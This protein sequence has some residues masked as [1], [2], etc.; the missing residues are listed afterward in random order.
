MAVMTTVLVMFY[1]FGVMFFSFTVSSTDSNVVQSVYLFN[2]TMTLGLVNFS[3]FQYGL[4]PMLLLWDLHVFDYDRYTWQVRRNEDLSH[5]KRRSLRRFLVPEGDIIDW[6][7]AS[8]P[9]ISPTT[10]SL[11]H[12]ECFQ[13]TCVANPDFIDILTTNFIFPEADTFC[14]LLNDS[15]IG[16]YMFDDDSDVVVFVSGASVSISNNTKDFISWDTEINVPSFQGIT[17]RAPVQ[18]AGVVRWTFLDDKGIE[19]VVQIKA[20]F[21]PNAK[22]RLLSPQ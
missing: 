16:I 5:R 22:V 13:D 20:Y 19:S 8:V 12:S 3:L 10:M 14:D 11:W 2:Y 4:S 6:A 18:G 1:V 17:P 21:V 9:E 7:S 15:S